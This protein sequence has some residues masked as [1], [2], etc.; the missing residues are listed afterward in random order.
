[1]KTPGH[2]IRRDIRIF[3]SPVTRELGSVRKLVKKALDDNDYH[4]VEQDNFPPDYRTLK[5]M[6][7]ARI[8]SCDA[9]VHIVGRCYGAEPPVRPA[10]APRRSYTQLEYDVAVE[11][12]KP[13]Y[14]FVMAPEFATDP[15]EPEAPELQEL[16]TAHR[17]HLMSTGKHYNPVSSP[18]QLDQKLRSL[19]IKVEQ[20]K[21][22]LQQVDQKLDVHGARLRRWL[23]GGAVLVLAALITLGY[24]GWRQQ[25]DRRAQQEE[26]ARQHAERENQQAER[27]KQDRERI[28]A[29]AARKEAQTIQQVQQEFA[30]R[31]LQQLLTTQ[32][33]KPED[34]R[35]RALKELPALVKLPL[36][37]IQS[38]IDHK[39]G[40]RASEKSLSS[41]ERARAAL[42]K[43]NYD[44]V[45]QAAD[46]QKQQGRELAML[47]GTAALARFRQ[48]PKP[49]WNVLALAAFQRAMALADPNSPAE[50]ES[51]TD[52]ALS[53][54]SALQDLARFTEAE[55]LLRQCQRLREAKNGPDSAGV[56]VVL[57]NLAQ[58]LRAT[59]RLP[60]AESLYRRALAI[61]EK[62]SDPDDPDV[63]TDLNSLGRL[64]QAT[65]RL[66]AAEPLH[67]R[68]LAIHEQSDGPD[69]PHVAADLDNLAELLRDTNRLSAAEPLHRR[70]LAIWEKLAGPNHPSVGSSLHNLAWLLQATNRLSEPEPL[71]RR[72]LAI[73]ENTYGPDH[74]NVA[75]CLDNLARLLQA[76][77]RLSAA[78]PLHRRA[79]AIDEKSYGPDHPHVAVRAADLAMLLENTNRLSEAELLCRRAVAIYEKTYGP[80]HPGVASIQKNL[81]RLLRAT[82][83]LSEAE[84]LQRRVLAINEK[85]DGPDHPDVASDLNDM[86]ELLRATNRLAEAEPLLARAVRVLFQ[87]QR[88]TSNEHPRQTSFVENYRQ[89]LAELKVAEPEIARRV[90]AAREGTD[91]L[92]PI[93]PAVERL[94]GPARPVADV[95][96]SLDRQ[97]KQLGKPGVYFL[98]PDEP[99]APHLDELLHPSRD[100]LNAETVLAFRRGAYAD[101]LV[102]S[103]AELDLMADQPA[104]APAKLK[105]SVNRAA[106]LRE[107]GLITQARDE[108]VR[109]LPEIDQVLAL[110]PVTKGRTRF[111]LALCQ[112]RLGDRAA[113]QRSAGESLAAYDAAPKAIPV[114]PFFRRQ[115]EEVL[116]ALKAGK[117][118]PPL[119]KI[120]PPAALEAAHARYRARAALAKLPL[121]QKVAPLLNQ[122]LGPARS[123]QEV[124]DALNRS[125]RE[126]KKPAVWLLPLG[127]PIA[128]H[129]DQLLGPAKS[130]KEVLESLDRQYRAQRKPAV[131]FLPLKEPISPHLDELLGKPQK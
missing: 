30:E 25:L 127:V 27:D 53:T 107:L 110:D 8:G 109:L 97:Y 56:A 79:L 3:I 78:E 7:S 42:A 65:N 61:D 121:N 128:P 47:E 10:D 105:A 66:S 37:E 2:T 130:A 12:G 23:V 68:A 113:A 6:D 49:E 88:S 59:N 57:T 58:L 43:G 122:I 123:T 108:L 103:E 20:L 71:Y 54:A 94:L 41:L 126:E 63:A 129:L 60:E 99:I 117:A 118:P 131:W 18:E 80:D 4:A 22:E 52:A 1:M 5:D 98:K 69:H 24:I 73:H 64:L 28:A 50:W 46:D 83:R 15:H 26:Q 102:S 36:A 82:N 77:N 93:V 48:S 51:W 19:Q 38:L 72:A 16:Q 120:D 14:V 74:P 91:K 104:Q 75:A 87:F 11:L 89:L 62:S 86:A 119:A 76:T 114:A 92:S 40:P 70:A 125:Y 115:S 34:A 17:Q 95:L 67:R 21:D 31:F 84:P 96:T 106:A 124:L 85:A 100:G 35:Q 39:I 55:P 29:E 44:E 13:V 81:A 111:Q 33:I 112:W 45:F 101:A 32:E 9:V 116:A 90:K